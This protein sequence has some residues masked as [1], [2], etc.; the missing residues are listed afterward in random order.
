MQRHTFPK[1]RER[2]PAKDY[3]YTTELQTWQHDWEQP[4]VGAPEVDLIRFPFFDVRD[5][6]T[7]LAAVLAREVEPL[8]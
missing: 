8:R 4:E 7:L 3:I 1:V 6:R 2:S 5:Y